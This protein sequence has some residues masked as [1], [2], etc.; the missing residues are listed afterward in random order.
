MFRYGGAKSVGRLGGIFEQPFE[1]PCVFG[2]EFDAAFSGEETAGFLDGGGDDKTVERYTKDGG[3]VLE[4][5]VDGAVYARGD[6]GLQRLRGTVSAGARAL[7]D[8]ML[9]FGHKHW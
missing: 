8:D 9:I 1:K 5:L 4:D 6:P 3:S 2:S 7:R